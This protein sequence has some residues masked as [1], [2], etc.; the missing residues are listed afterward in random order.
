M[1]NLRWEVG[2]VASMEKVGYELLAGA[3]ELADWAA[4]RIKTFL[5]PLTSR[6]RDTALPAGTLHVGRLS[7][8]AGRRGLR[9]VQLL[10]SDAHEGPR[11]AI[12]L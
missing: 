11:Q 2:R 7:A 4:A 9:G 10:I 12:V 3:D 8:L 1:G 6:Q 5:L